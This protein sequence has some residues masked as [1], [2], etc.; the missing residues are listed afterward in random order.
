MNVFF[1]CVCVENVAHVHNEFFLTIKKN[2]I[3]KF[4]V[5]WMK[6]EN[7]ILC[8]L[9]QAQKYKCHMLYLICGP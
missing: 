9:T 6:L 5:R 7:S 1:V 8:E 2:E 4:A 3:I